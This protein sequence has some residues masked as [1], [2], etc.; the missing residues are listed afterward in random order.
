[1]ELLKFGKILNSRPSGHEAALR[2]KQIINGQ[3]K[4][5]KTIVLDME[6]IDVLTP[7]FADEFIRGVK[8]LYPKVKV[9]LKGYQSNPVLQQTLQTIGLLD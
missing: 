4:E 9:E 3:G 8:D 5:V 6:D 2:V 1:M 7:S